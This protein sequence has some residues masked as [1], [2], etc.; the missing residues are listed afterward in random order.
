MDF[1][2]VRDRIIPRLVNQEMNKDILCERP[3]MPVADLAVTYHVMLDEFEGNMASVPVGCDLLNVWE[4]DVSEIHALAIRN[5][6]MCTPSIYV[7]LGAMLE[8]L[9]RDKGD[10]D[11]VE[12]SQA[13]GLMYVLTNRQ[14]LNGAAAVLDP[15][16][17]GKLT[18][19]FGGDSNLIPSSI[20]EWIVVSA[21]ATD[22]KSIAEMVKEVNAT[23]VADEDVLSDHAYRF[24]VAEG[25]VA[26]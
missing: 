12:L 9:L 22:P 6:H 2:K 17:A 20:H 21:K 13:D 19:S 25:L 23:Q 26:V 16:M 14:K 1:N 5:M 11:L 15:E 8:P 10:E 18:E 4:K 24:T 7:P 3:H